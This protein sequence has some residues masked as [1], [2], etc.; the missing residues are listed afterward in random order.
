MSILQVFLCALA[1][2]VATGFGA[3]P[4]IFVKSLSRR[5]LGA[6]NAVAAGL[7]LAA[8]FGL[9]YE[10]VNYGLLRTLGGA[11]IG[12]GFIVLVR[13]VLQRDE[14]PAVF[15]GMSGMD[16]RKALLIVGVMTVHS[17][18]EGVG[19]GV[20]FGGGVGLAYSS[21]LRWFHRT[22]QPKLRFSALLAASGAQQFKLVRV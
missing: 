17:F 8:R 9:I 22:N 14:H 11:L 4:F 12:L 18:T 1:T 3:L 6:S 5:W 19:V 10:G 16:A 21:R 2:A 15:T 13:R 20:S 7:M